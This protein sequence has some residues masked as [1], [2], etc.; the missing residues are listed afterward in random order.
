MRTI[1]YKEAPEN[2]ESLKVLL[3]HYFDETHPATYWSDSGKIQCRDGCNRSIDD[4]ILL[5]NHYFPG[6]TCKDVLN[7]YVELTKE[8]QLT[9]KDG[10][11][12]FF[13]CGDIKRPVLL[14]RIYTPD[15]KYPI[16]NLILYQNHID[17]KCLNSEHTLK[18]MKEL[19]DND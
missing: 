9:N 15:D 5:A 1:Y 16:C 2:P 7:V 8:L 11:F 3:K 17:L 6:S 14:N 13:H 12:C 4:L 18:S 10:H 19:L